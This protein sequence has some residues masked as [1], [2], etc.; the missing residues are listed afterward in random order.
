MKLQDMLKELGLYLKSDGE[1]LTHLNFQ[2]FYFL[3]LTIL[4]LYNLFHLSL[5]ISFLI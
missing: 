3:N 4:G 5:C 2:K 1:L